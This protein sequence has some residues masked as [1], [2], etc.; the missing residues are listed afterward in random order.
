MLPPDVHESGL[1]FTPV[2]ENIRFGI[3][4]IKNVGENTA[5][6]IFEAREKHGN[7]VN[8]FDFCEK[9]ETTT[10]NKRVLESLVKAGALD[11]LRASRA[12]LWAEL[13]EA[14][15]NGQRRQQAKR[16]G[17]QGI[18]GASATSEVAEQYRPEHTNVAEW[19]EDELL[20]GEHSVLGFYVSGH[21]MDKYAG[22]L[23]DLK[24]TELSALEGKSDGTPVIIAGVIVQG[25]ALRTRKGKR[26]GAFTL[27]DRTGL[28]ELVVYSEP[29]A[30]LEAVLEQ[31]IP[32]VVKGRVSIDDREGQDASR[33]LRVSVEDAKPLE[34]MLA[35]A[36][37]RLR[38]RVRL[39]D[40][41]GD[42]M[43][44][45]QT[46]LSER[47]GR[48]RVVFDLERAEGDTATLEASS[49]VAVDEKLLAAVRGLCGE[50]S[51]TVE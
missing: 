49:A 23:E 8:I 46:L 32:L 30:R 35:S 28:M 6:A 1:Y 2:G 29:F 42:E 37:V 24:I 45:L 15:K 25:K 5:K 22:R 41:Q 27:Q 20:G 3:A 36:P 4:A 47:P 17:Q 48:S 51:V 13:D 44:R 19:S 16:S 9:I 26:M 40:V 10:L 11:S 14:L 21:P 50:E 31:K 38:I 34:K 18:F 7:F 43:E 33:A 12:C 39:A